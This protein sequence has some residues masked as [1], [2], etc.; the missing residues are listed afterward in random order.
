MKPQTYLSRSDRTTA[1]WLLSVQVFVSCSLFKSHY[2]WP[3]HRTS[4]Q[5]S[6][7]QLFRIS[8]YRTLSLS[9]SFK[10]LYISFSLNFITTSPTF[11]LYISLKNLYLYLF[12]SP[13]LVLLIF[14]TISPNIIT[15]I[16][17][18]TITHPSSL[19]LSCNHIGPLSSSRQILCF[20]ARSFVL[21]Y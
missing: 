2:P 1:Q 11:S 16:T 19:L 9:N 3:Y 10:N 20:A 17:H 12:F 15:P 13:S 14:L 6:F 21:I 18:F 5:R 4:L 8:R 7:R